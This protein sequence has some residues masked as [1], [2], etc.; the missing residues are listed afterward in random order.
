MREVPRLILHL[1]AVL[2]SSILNKERWIH[3]SLLDTCVSPPSQ[4]NFHGLVCLLCCYK[5]CLKTLFVISF[6]FLKSTTCCER[7]LQ[8]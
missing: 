1:T 8:C 6:L 2:F 3:T 5:V 7:V 4:V